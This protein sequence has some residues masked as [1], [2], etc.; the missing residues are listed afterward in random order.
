MRLARP[1]GV[2]GILVCVVLRGRLQTLLS[3]PLVERRCGRLDRRRTPAYARTVSVVAVLN[4]L[5]LLSES[6]MCSLGYPSDFVTP[7]T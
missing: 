4:R 6:R 5:I 3:M 1:L 7:P 2:A